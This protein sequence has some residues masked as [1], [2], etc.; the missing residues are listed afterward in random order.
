MHGLDTSN[1]SSRVESSQVEFELM[2][3]VN[4]RSC[5]ICDLSSSV[6][7]LNH[8]ILQNILN[9]NKNEQKEADR[10]TTQI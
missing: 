9:K 4:V 2:S 10:A 3:D 6:K 1:V 8:I 5:K 7:V